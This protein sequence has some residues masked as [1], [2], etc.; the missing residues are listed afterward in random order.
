MHELSLMGDVLDLVQRDARKRGLERIT[1]VRLLVG[2]LSNAM[3]D[4]LQMAFLMFR[5][6]GET[7]LTEEAELTV[8][9]EEAKAVCVLCG[10]EYVPDR[11]VAVCPDCGLPSGK[12]VSGEAF[13][14]LSYEGS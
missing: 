8:E 3:P 1:G 4:A 7:P 10:L 5:A 12:L 11:T 9:T 6:G 14:V 13:R 2:T